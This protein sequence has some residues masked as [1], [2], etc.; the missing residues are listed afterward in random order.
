M[1]ERERMKVTAN[2]S[3]ELYQMKPYHDS[4]SFALCFL[5]KI[6]LD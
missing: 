3:H 6:P 2:K 4:V 1:R 5:L